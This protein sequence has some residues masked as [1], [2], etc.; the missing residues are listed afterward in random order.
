MACE[1]D[2]RSAIEALS[3]LGPAGDALRAAHPWMRNEGFRGLAMGINTVNG[4]S[5]GEL[6]LK[7]FI[8]RK[9]PV[10]GDEDAVPAILRLPGLDAAIPTDVDEVGEPGLQFTQPAAGGTSIKIEGGLHGTFGCLVTPRRGPSGLFL[11]TSAHVIGYSRLRPAAPGTPVFEVARNGDHRV[12]A[13]LTAYKPLNFNPAGLTQIDAAIARI[14]TPAIT[15]DIDGRGP[16]KGVNPSPQIGDKLFAYVDGAWKATTRVTTLNAMLHKIRMQDG[17][18]V[19]YINYGGMI[20]CN[21]FTKGGDSG[22]LIVD[23]YHNAVG[24][25]VGG[26]HADRADPQT[27]ICPM[28][29][30]LQH[31]GVELVTRDSIGRTQGASPWTSAST[32]ASPVASAGAADTLT[33]ERLKKIAKTGFDRSAARNIDSHMIHVR[34]GLREEGLDDRDMILMALAT[35]KAETAGFVPVSEPPHRYNTSKFGRPGQGADY[36]LYEDRGNLGNTE[37]GDGKR[38]RGR[39][40][41][42]LTGRFNY[43]EVG[44]RIGV[45]LIADPDRAND[46]KTAGRILASFLKQREGRIR[47]A[48]TEDRMADA[49][50]LVNGGRHGLERF[51]TCYDAVADVWDRTV[52]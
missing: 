41:I 2:I 11:L 46:P 19:R 52:V 51:E 22:A 48:L 16:P 40:F 30:I 20:T 4:N 7:V 33:L 47:A 17:T 25:V 29:R 49:R 43:D 23:R 14:T 18:A 34:D 10:D 8:D 37:P 38:F 15:A 32:P 12:I 45:D 42:Q 36:D 35:I 13:A 21:A 50:A 5:T 6:V 31:F 24:L 26:D 3:Q 39:G 28:D 27:Y 1:E 9:L 44:G